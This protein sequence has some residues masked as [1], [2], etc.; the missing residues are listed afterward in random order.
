[1]KKCYYPIGCCLLAAVL[2]VAP[3]GC[4]C[5]ADALCVEPPVLPVTIVDTAGDTLVWGITD[6]SVDSIHGFE[7]NVEWEVFGFLGIRRVQNWEKTDTEYGL[8]ELEEDESK[9]RV[10]NFTWW[11]L[12]PN[13]ICGKTRNIQYV[14]GRMHV[15][16]FR[17]YDRSGATWGGD[18]S[19]PYE[20]RWVGD[21]SDPIENY[22]WPI[23]CTPNAPSSG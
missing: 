21:Q 23:T 10:P 18:E 12:V 1:M 17:Y 19:I 11:G 8:L 20:G 5:V 6:R 16:V 14:S 9:D 15:R 13:D 3:A 4:G 2:A 22:S 7:L